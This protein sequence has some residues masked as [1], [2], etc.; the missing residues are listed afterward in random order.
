MNLF[1]GRHYLGYFH[2]VFL[3]QTKAAIIKVHFQILFECLVFVYIV[4]QLLVNVYFMEFLLG[5]CFLSK[6]Q[7]FWVKIYLVQ[8]EKDESG[9][10]VDL[11]LLGAVLS[12]RVLYPSVQSSVVSGR[13][14]II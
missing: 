12:R 3:L 8:N 2:T 7:V 1:L 9:L 14:L 5:M 4:H 6:M 13:K 11:L 10:V